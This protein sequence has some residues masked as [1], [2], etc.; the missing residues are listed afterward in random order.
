M[1]RQKIEKIL[2]A[3]MAAPSAMNQQPWEF[4][5]V[6]DKK[7]LQELSEASPYAGMTAGA[8]AAFVLCSRKS[9][10]R[11]PELVD[12]DMSLA[13]EN[14]LLEIEEQGLGG[15]MLGIAPFA[16]RMEKVAKAVNAPDSLSV[17]TVI[18]FGYPLKKNPQ[19][20]RYDAAR[21]HYVK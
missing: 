18:P 21:V 16:D 20:D 7:A 8:P 9:D 5:V 17:F 15:V 4:Y 2:R 6:T 3:A 1:R 13:T 12:V 11:V 14:I 19:Q 10:V